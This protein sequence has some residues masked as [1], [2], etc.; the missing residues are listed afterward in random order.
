V[1]ARFFRTHPDQPWGPPS[2]LNNGYW[3]S[4]LGA[5]WLGH[6]VNHPLASSAEVKEQVEQYIYSPLLAF[7]AF[8]RE[9]LVVTYTRFLTYIYQQINWTDINPLLCFLTEMFE[10]FTISIIALLIT[11]CNRMVSFFCCLWLNGSTVYFTFMSQ[12]LHC[13]LFLTCAL[14]V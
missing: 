11:V 2:L 9:N 13:S 8:S 3:V 12:V 10:M 14:F 5:K 1:E 4:F 7:M 6:G